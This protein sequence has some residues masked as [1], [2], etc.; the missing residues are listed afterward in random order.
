MTFVTDLRKTVTDAT[1]VMAAVGITDLAVEKVREAR[2]Q[3]LATSKALAAID[4]KGVQHELTA[5]AEK[6]AQQAL[7][8]PAQLFNRGLELAGRAQEQYGD[9][10]ARG[11]KL[12]QRLR[13]QQS[14]K[15]LV[16]QVDQTVATGKGAITT[17]RKA[18]ASTQSSAKATFTTGRKEATRTAGAIRDTVEDDV[19]TVAPVVRASAKRTRTAAK[20][21]ATTARK[22]ADSTSSR[23]KATTTSARKTTTRARKASA[24]TA[25]K[26]G[27]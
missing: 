6:S 22:G 15:D 14:T 9:L 18:V 10:A 13:T 3:A 26:V 20:R 7:E 27:D 16:A 25:A 4:P 5:Q 23:A 2:A 11:E 12:V 19:K 24:A 21:T 8:T 1:P 17:A